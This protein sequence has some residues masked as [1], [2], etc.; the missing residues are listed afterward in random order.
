[1]CH[2]AYMPIVDSVYKREVGDNFVK[3][4]TCVTLVT[5]ITKVE[6]SSPYQRISHIGGHGWR[7]THE[8]AIQGIQNEQYVF[9]ILLKGEKTVELTIGLY[10]DIIYLKTAVD[11]AHPNH[12]LRLP[13]CSEKPIAVLKKK[14]GDEGNAETSN[15]SKDNTC[16]L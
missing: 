3:A 2:L 16:S 11:G 12:L 15:K 1:M 4:T 10:E 5:C 13:E 6:H 9:Y 14:S 7:F 8:E